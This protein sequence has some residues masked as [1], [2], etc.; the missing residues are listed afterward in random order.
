MDLIVIYRVSH[1]F[2]LA[3]QATS[4]TMM[5]LYKFKKIGITPSILPDHKAIKNLANAEI[6]RGRTTQF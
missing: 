6:H 2:N 4:G 3:K 5:N 1:T